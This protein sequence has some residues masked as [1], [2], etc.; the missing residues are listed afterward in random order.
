MNRSR[1]HSHLLQAGGEGFDL[2]FVLL[3]AL[4]GL[5]RT[6]LVTL[7]LHCKRQITRSIFN[8]RSNSFASYIQLAFTWKSYSAQ[9]C[10][11]HGVRNNVDRTDVLIRITKVGA[12]LGTFFTNI[13]Q[14]NRIFFYNNSSSSL[15]FKFSQ[16][17]NVRSLYLRGLVFKWCTFSSETSRDFRLLPTTRSS[18]SSSTILLRIRKR[19]INF[20]C[21]KKEIAVFTKLSFEVTV[22]F[23]S[24]IKY[25]K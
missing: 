1:S 16:P 3:F 5:Y 15:I 20:Y 8:T 25:L 22:G 10:S 19:T 11:L 7:R 14:Y 13:A 6:L 24:L 2:I 9:P 21:S 23:Q 12:S 18:S 17:M 4:V